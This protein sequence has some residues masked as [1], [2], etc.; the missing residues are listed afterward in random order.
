MKDE[1]EQIDPQKLKAAI[2]AAQLEANKAS[3]LVADLK[4]TCKHEFK[5]LTPKQLAD[6]WMSEGAHCLICNEGFGWRCKESPDGVCHYF[7]EDGKVELITGELVSPPPEHDVEYE[8]DDD[9]LW[10]GL[11]DERK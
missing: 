11:P 7:T 4:A 3:R 2:D 10:C 5:P 1:I 6:K 8:S 9:C